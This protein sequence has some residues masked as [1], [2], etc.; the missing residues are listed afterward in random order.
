MYSEFQKAERELLEKLRFAAIKTLADMGEDVKGV[1][2]FSVMAEEY[3]NSKYGNVRFVD[4]ASGINYHHTGV[5]RKKEKR[6]E[7]LK[8]VA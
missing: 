7:Q 6:K 1:E 5:E 8:M 3:C 2:W 4:F